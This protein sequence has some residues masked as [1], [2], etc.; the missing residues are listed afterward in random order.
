MIHNLGFILDMT[1]SFYATTLVIVKFLES[2]IQYFYYPFY[3]Y[4]WFSKIKCVECVVGIHMGWDFE[5]C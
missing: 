1:C 2:V 3:K 5:K 4:N